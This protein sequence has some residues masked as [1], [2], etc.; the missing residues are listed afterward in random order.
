LNRASAIVFARGIARD[1]LVT[2]DVRGRR[3]GRR[4]SFPLVMV[5]VD[6]QRYLVSMLG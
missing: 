1:Y 5:K 4:I 3:S 6:G 2:L